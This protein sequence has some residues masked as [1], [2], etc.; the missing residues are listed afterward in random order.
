MRHV[1]V[2]LSGGIDS[3]VSVALLKEQGYQVTAVYMKNWSRDIAGHHCPWQEDL[4]S[5]RLVAA[6]LSIPLK[7]YDFEQQYYE[8]ITQYMIDT[9]E[10]G[11][12]PNPDIMCNQKIKFDVFYKQCLQEGADAVATGHYAQMQNGQLMCAKDTTKDQT[13]FLYRIDP[14]IADTILFPLSN[15]LKTEVRTYAKDHALPNAGR[16]ESQ[17][18][19][20]VGN[21]PLRDFLSEFIQPKEGDIVDE[22][23]KVVGKHQG[24]YAY[25]IGQRHGLG[26]GG[27]QPYYVY[28][29]DTNTNVVYVTT[30]QQSPFLFQQEFTITD[31]VLWQQPL[32]DK[33]YQIRVRYRS[34]TKPGKIVHLKDDEWQITM[35]EPEKAVTAGQSA[36]LY[37]GSTVIGG[38]II[39]SSK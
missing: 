9:Y 15:M 11:Q 22:T 28:D 1:F 19:C 26:V 37:D 23:G 17:G 12:T 25:T 21:I 27:G 18:L 39:Q 13:Y 20:F 7:V 34:T 5:A 30:D 38:G 6:H 29:T 14:S 33:T 36:V 8:S 31:P 10:S 16:A 2:G 4:A 24:A 35:D 3:A 32:A